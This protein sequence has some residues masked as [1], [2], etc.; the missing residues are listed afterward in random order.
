MTPRTGLA[1]LAAMVA[2]AA[3][4]AASAQH[5]LALGNDA[6]T[7]GQSVFVNVWDAT[8]RGTAHYC[9]PH[10]GFRDV[11]FRTITRVEITVFLHRNIDCSRPVG[12]HTMARA[13]AIVQGRTRKVIGLSNGVLTVRD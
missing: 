9:V 12:R 8:S 7:V 1:A 6:G 4:A 11:P 3:P 13:A 2:L 5:L 10:G